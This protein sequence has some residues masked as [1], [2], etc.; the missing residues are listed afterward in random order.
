MHLELH[1]QLTDK[2]RRH[3]IE[4][5][6]QS[7]YAG[8]AP[9]PMAA[10]LHQ[11]EKQSITN[12]RIDPEGLRHCFEDMV[13]SEELAVTLGAALSHGHSLLL[14]G[15]PGNGKTIYSEAVVRSFK[16]PIYIPYSVEI[17]GQV[18]SVFD[19]AVHEQLPDP[20]ADHDPRWVRCR[21]P[22]VVAGGELTMD[23]LELLFDPF[24]K[25]YEAPLQLKATGGVFIIDDFGRQSVPPE[26]ILNRWIVPLE[27][28]RDYLALHSG[29][30]VAVPFDELLI[31]STNLEP[32]SFLDAAMMRRI[33]YKI[34]IGPPDRGEFANIMAAV[35]Q[36]HGIEPPADLVAHLFE[37]YYDAGGLEPAR[38]H[39]EWIAQHVESACAY[40]GV[41]V[42]L[43][44][45]RVDEAM[46]HLAIGGTRGGNTPRTGR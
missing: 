30:K 1:F 17:D 2:G 20:E 31:F 11:I 42:N 13:I 32:E 21:R 10:Y 33:H 12:E 7:H 22:A 8:P 45:G 37:R 28:K 4:A 40:E 43:D 23:M 9:V 36:S 5:L 27:R 29:K 19:P 44:H 15:P 38:F 39:P 24:D 3:A 34:E 41:P 6:D 14:Y 26:R 18:I 16:Q 46:G 25:V 35:C